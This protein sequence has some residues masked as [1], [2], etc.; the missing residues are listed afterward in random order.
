MLNSY[1]E[2]LIE[3]FNLFKVVATTEIGAFLD[4]GFSKDLF[5]PF[6]EQTHKLKKGESVIVYTYRDQRTGRL[7]GSTRV[8]RFID[9]ACA[10]LSPE[11]EVDLLIYD[12]TDIGFKAI[13]NNV[14]GG[15]LFKEEIFQPL[16]YGQKIKGYIKRIR[17]DGKID[18]CLHKPGY[19]QMDA[20]S[21]KIMDHLKVSGGK[22]K[23]TDKTAPEEIYRL[24]GISKKKFKMACGLLYKQRLIVIDQDGIKVT[25]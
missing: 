2:D 22:S 12:E 19:R 20:L 16:V 25:G 11:D 9:K 21:Q 15:L 13:I 10:N 23:L 3:T 18:L 8:D 6:R 7:V 17:D 1:Q 24:F 5:V 14:V 4:C